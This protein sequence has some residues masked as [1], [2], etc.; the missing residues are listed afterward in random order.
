MYIYM[1]TMPVTPWT[2]G[3]TSGI[4]PSVTAARMN[5]G[6]ERGEASA[7]WSRGVCKGTTMTMTSQT[8][9]NGGTIG[10]DAVAIMR[11]VAETDLH[12][13]VAQDIAPR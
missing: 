8:M 6:V 7:G 13:H 2:I 5:S 1:T 3:G 11:S 9:V 10:P 12:C 4:M